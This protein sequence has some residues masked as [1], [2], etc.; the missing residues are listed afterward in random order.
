LPSFIA[1]LRPPAGPFPPVLNVGQADTC[2]YYLTQFV[3][4]LQPLGVT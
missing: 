1:A 2:H 4:S 3:P